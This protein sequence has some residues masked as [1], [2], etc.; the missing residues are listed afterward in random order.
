[1]RKA[2]IC[3]AFI[4]PMWSVLGQ[5]EDTSFDLNVYIKNEAGFQCNVSHIT[6]SYAQDNQWNQQQQKRGRKSYVV[7][8]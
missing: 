5:S 1:M 6:A 7:D 3:E 8:S 2:Q 4:F